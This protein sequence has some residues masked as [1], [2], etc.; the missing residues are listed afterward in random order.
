MSVAD[1]LGESVGFAAMFDAIPVG[2][3][4]VDAQRRIVLMN[5]A[6]HASLGLD[7]GR[8]GPGTKVEDAVRASAW[9]GVYGPGDPELQAKA[10][11][12]A[13][14]SRSGR[15]RRRTFAGRSFDLFNT[16]LPDGGYIVTALDV[17]GLLAAR[18]DAA[19]ALAQTATALATLRI[20][21]GIFNAQGA[22]LLSNPRFAELMDIPPERISPGFTFEQM[23]GLMHDGDAFNGLDGS[24]FIDSLRQIEHGRHWTTRRNRGDGQLIDV[25]SD[26]LPAGGWALT[27]NDVTPLIHAQDEALRRARLLDSVLLAVPH[28]ICVYGPDRRVLMFNQTYQDVM[29][30]AP[31]QVG[32]HLNDVIRRRA[33]AGEYGPGTP[34]AVFQQQLGF[35]ISRTQSRRRVRP[36]GSA[37]DIRT[38][39]LPDGGHISVV[40][41]ITALVQAEALSR[42]RAEQI[43]VMLDSLHHGIMLWG[44]DK[45]LIAS[46]PITCQLYDL[47]ADLLTAGRSEAE[48]VDV[49]LRAGHFG[50]GSA[51]AASAQALTLRDRSVPHEREIRTPAGRVLSVQ[52]N[53]IQG[54][55]WVSTIVDVTKTQ[56]AEAELRQAKSV[57]EA[58]NAAKSRFL[59]TMSHELRTPL[60]AVIGFSDA[61]LRAAG[62]GGMAPDIQDYGAQ[63]NTAGKQLLALINTILDVAR[64]ESGRFDPGDEVVDIASLLRRAVRQI[65]SA[66]QAAEVT[67]EC[68]P[69]DDLPWVRADERRLHQALSQLLSNAVK[70][71]AAGGVV[72]VRAEPDADGGLRLSVADTGIGIPPAELERVFEPFT[73]LD[74]TL[75]RRYGGTGLGL[76]TARAIVAA[77]GGEIR[78]SSQQGVGTTAEIII[79]SRRVVH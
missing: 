13:D 27:L 16:P 11:L 38:A 65:E 66:A 30:G 76:Y 33:E 67:L 31:I 47:P 42:R 7:P 50:A 21:L 39:P 12:S 44:P 29:S 78:L 64:I 51:A 26:P 43:G 2:L 41:D 17:S 32:D 63:I 9:R 62:Q 61:L 25:M 40:T 77:Q 57:A 54:G 24:A 69:P 55:G 73:Q 70:F 19:S 52:S 4:V 59:A 49:M 14:H 36:N 18:A 37:I 56:A 53:P 15:L 60:N 46:N 23:L 34:D 35:D 8:F 79:P 20:G 28:G 22:L 74:D 71:T 3:A 72:R 1:T 5:P 75:S 58:A 68:H 6:F 48:V 45:R 10:V